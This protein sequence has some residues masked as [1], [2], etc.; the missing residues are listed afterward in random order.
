[1][2][3]SIGRQSTRHPNWLTYCDTSCWH[4]EPDGRSAWFSTSARSLYATKWCSIS[5][6]YWPFSA[7]SRRIPQAPPQ[8]VFSNG[9]H[10]ARTESFH[11]LDGEDRAGLFPKIVAIAAQEKPATVI[12]SVTRARKA[13]ATPWSYCREPHGQHNAIV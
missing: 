8:T 5:H 6:M 1:M 13:P 9:I 4:R 11:G 10:H 2:L 7:V 12:P 3:M